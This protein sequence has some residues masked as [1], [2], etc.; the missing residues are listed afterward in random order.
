MA[1]Y[2][3]PDLTIHQTVK[4]EDAKG[5]CTPLTPENLAVVTAYTEDQQR[6]IGNALTRG[7]APVY[8]EPTNAT[9][10]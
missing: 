5:E 4:S 1:P 9:E 3:I 7:L 2:E 8:P 6:M 10:K